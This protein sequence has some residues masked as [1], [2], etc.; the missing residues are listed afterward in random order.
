[1]Y[2]FQLDKEEIIRLTETVTHNEH[3]PHTHN[4][5]EIVYISEGNGTHTI[6]ENA[7]PVKRGDLLFINFKE[8]HSYS[9]QTSMKYIN[10]LLSPEFMGKE[11]INSENAMDIL[12]L[13]TFREFSDIAG[14]ICPQISFYGSDL[15]EVEAIL[16]FMINEYTRK[17][18]GYITVL[19]GYVNVLLSKIFR[20]FST[21]EH[22]ELAGS[23]NRIAPEVLQFIE[24]N[25]NKKITLKELAT[26]SFYNASY[27]STVFKECF[28]K[29]PL[30]YISEKRV[31]KAVELMGK[32]N[33]SIEDICYNVGYSNKKH[34]YKIFRNITGMTPNG[35][36]KA[37]IKHDI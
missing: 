31:E 12:T 33:L 9:T 37:N 21:A 2:Q 14:G 10:C 11:L 36:R 24:D 28:G 17:A 5:I 19:K 7:Y 20:N 23:L 25:Y 6:N 27:F 1:M 35:Y 22:N 15:L 29:T 34:F 18:R 30:E 4:F 13:S 32:T 16:G 26:R 3:F 8:V